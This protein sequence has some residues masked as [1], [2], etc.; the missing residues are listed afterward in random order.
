MNKGEELIEDFEEKV[1]YMTGAYYSIPEAGEQAFIEAV[2]I[3]HKARKDL[4][5][6]VAGLEKYISD[7]SESMNAREEELDDFTP[8]DFDIHKEHM[9][10]M[11]EINREEFTSFEDELAKEE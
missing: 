1:S 10:I 11:D 6:Y 2:N 9:D 3:A 5:D 7:M 4:I 8:R